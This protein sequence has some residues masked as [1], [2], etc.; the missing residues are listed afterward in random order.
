[1]YDEEEIRNLIKDE[2]NYNSFGEE[3]DL[4]EDL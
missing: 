4:P 3:V 2:G 1:M